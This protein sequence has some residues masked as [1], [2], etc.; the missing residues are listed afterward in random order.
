ME[1]TKIEQLLAAYFE[2]NTTLVEE[3]ILREYFSS[4]EVAPHLAMYQPLFIGLQQAKDEVS[5]K[6]INL[7]SSSSSF[8]SNKWWYG[9][10]ALLVVG[11][12]IGSFMFSQPQLSQEEKEALAAFEKS[13]E[14][15]R[16][17]SENLNKGTEDLAYLNEFAKG[18]SSIS[19]I[20]QFTDTIETPFTS[21]SSPT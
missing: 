16:L 19:H 20:N 12:T 1:L 14:T 7:L 17:L 5:R 2:G 13:K 15:L 10:A 18:T 4:S 6:E 9:I 11:V 21:I 8:T 3:S